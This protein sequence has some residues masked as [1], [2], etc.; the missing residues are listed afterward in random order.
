MVNESEQLLVFL[1]MVVQTRGLS[2]ENKS[3]MLNEMRQVPPDVLRAA[4]VMLA[5][6]QCE[7]M[8]A[9]V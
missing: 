2:Y 6:W 8:W 5:P 4:W 3:V 1:Q 7:R 9:I